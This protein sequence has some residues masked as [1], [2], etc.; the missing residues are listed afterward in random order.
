VPQWHRS[1]LF[2][3][4][5]KW[6]PREAVRSYTSYRGEFLRIK[7]AIMARKS[8]R[9]VRLTENIEIPVPVD[10]TQEEEAVLVAKFK[11]DHDLAELE[12][13]YRRLARTEETFPLE[14]LI[15]E[16]QETQK[17]FDEG[18]V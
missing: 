7:G 8:Y 12:N 6:L 5:E 13:D 4:N 17:Q 18:S 2:A 9:F 16:L 10:C 14:D 15:R 1:D 11:A 3:A